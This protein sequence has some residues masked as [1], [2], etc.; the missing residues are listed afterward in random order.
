[1]KERITTLVLRSFGMSNPNPK[2]AS[3]DAAV[4]AIQCV[5]SP[6]SDGDKLIKGSI[7]HGKV[8]SIKERLSFCMPLQK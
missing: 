3:T 5:D 1:M 8:T 7:I 4:I 6:N 2:T